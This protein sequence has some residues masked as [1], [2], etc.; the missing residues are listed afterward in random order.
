MTRKNAYNVINRALV[1]LRQHSIFLRTLITTVLAAFIPLILVSFFLISREKNNIDDAAHRQLMSISS[2]VA[3]Q[4]DEFIDSALI[5][6]TKMQLDSTLYPNTINRT[7][8]SEIEALARIK[9]MQSGVPFT[10]EYGLY[11]HGSS[12]QAVYSSTGK[13]YPSVYARYIVGMDTQLFTQSMLSKKIHFIEWTDESNN[14]LLVI[15]I[16][17]SRS[18]DVTRAGFYM[19]THD[20]L[21]MALSNLLADQCH[22]AAIYDND[23]KIIY[24][25]KSLVRVS[26]ASC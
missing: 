8:Y 20:S 5:I 17:N 25:N 6:N 22:I 18:S 19:L 26:K 4:F 3:Q 16:I 2:S 10:E 9:Y 24:K 12:T 21:T 14:M 23:G 7:I 15:P 1:W 11:I 13:Y